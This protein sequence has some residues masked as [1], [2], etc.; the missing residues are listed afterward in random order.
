M[1][2]KVYEHARMCVCTHM[3]THR[4]RFVKIE[5]EIK[6]TLEVKGYPSHQKLEEGFG[7]DFPFRSTKRN[8]SYQHLCF[9]L[10]THKCPPF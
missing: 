4:R 2:T 3:H 9:R 5:R 10:Q 6:A 7:T 1:K 8:Q